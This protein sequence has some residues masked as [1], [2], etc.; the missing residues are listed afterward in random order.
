[1]DCKKCYEVGTA[2]LVK[3]RQRSTEQRPEYE[4]IPESVKKNSS[5]ITAE[6][7]SSINTLRLIIV[8]LAD[9][10]IRVVID[11]AEGSLR[12][13]YQPLDVLQ[14]GTNLK[15]EDFKYFKK[16]A[17][18]VTFVLENGAQ[19]MVAFK[20]F[21]ILVY[22]NGEVVVGLN[23]HHLLKFEHYRKKVPGKEKDD[24]EGFWEETFKTHTDSKPHGSSSVGMDISFVGF[25]YVYG[26]PEHGDSFVLRSTSAMDPY[27][28]FNLDVFEYELNS[29]MS[30]YGAV[31][32][33][34]AHSKD[35]S[36]A[37]LWLNAA[38]TWVDINSPLDSKGIF[39]SLADKLKIT[40]DA[41]EVSTH[42]ISETG[43]IDVFIMLGPKPADIFRQNGALTGFYPLPPLF[44]LAYHQSRWNYNDQDDVA[45]VHANFDKYDIPVD[46]IWLDIEH[47]DG[48]RYFTWDQAKFS[49]PLEMIDAL[50]TKVNS[51]ISDS[52]VFS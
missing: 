28:L 15:T 20:P 24:G 44:S 52:C 31:P 5:A 35:R 16:E 34:M 27:R 41:P 39:G 25:K 32:F 10:T 47:T 11:E 38:E 21:Q 12:P 9:S 14:N 37:A 43:L 18:M 46:V 7:K 30:L 26:L 13:R 49:T 8:S 17:S 51:F 4:I 19:V 33:I 2:I 40:S 29:Q 45:A 3:E 22:I 48:K 23:S 6:L 36:V 42:F 50:V 1:M